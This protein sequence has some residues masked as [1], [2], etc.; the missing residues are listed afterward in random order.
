[1]VFSFTGLLVVSHLVI[2]IG[3]CLSPKIFK[4]D[5]TTLSQ[6]SAG[7]IHVPTRVHVYQALNHRNALA[8]GLE[9]CIMA[10]RSDD[11]ISDRLWDTSVCACV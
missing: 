10:I 11:A 1:M 5:L 6:R 9:P 7:Q 8:V 4:P 2:P 3:L